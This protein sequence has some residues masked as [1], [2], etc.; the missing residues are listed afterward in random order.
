MPLNSYEFKNFDDLFSNGLLHGFA[1]QIYGVN[2]K[3][4]YQDNRNDFIVD[5]ATKF[6]IKE[7]GSTDGLGNLD[8]YKDK[9][10]LKKSYAANNGQCSTGYN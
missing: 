10:E 6:E 4:E 9:L 5:L 2:G 8:T 3:K 7:L 1:T